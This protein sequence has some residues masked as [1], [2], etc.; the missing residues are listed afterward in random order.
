MSYGAKV[1]ICSGINIKYKY[2]VCG[3]NV[4]FL[5]V[6]PVGASGNQEALEG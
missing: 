4:K 3:Q 5:N 2:T 6:E 1:V